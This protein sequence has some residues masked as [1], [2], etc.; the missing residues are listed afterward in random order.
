MAYA[1]IVNQIDKLV[2]MGVALI[3]MEGIVLLMF[4]KVCPL[5]ILARQYSASTQANFDIYLPNW[6]AKQNKLIYTTF[7]ILIFCG[8]IYRVL[9]R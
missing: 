9:N 3:L 8:I 6:V 4:K 7:F 1:V 2:W 5:T